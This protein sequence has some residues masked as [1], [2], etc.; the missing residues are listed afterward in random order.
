MGIRKGNPVLG[1]FVNVRSMDFRFG[2]KGRDVSITQIIRHA[3]ELTE[4]D[5]VDFLKL[6]FISLGYDEDIVKRLQEQNWNVAL[7]YML[8]ERRNSSDDALVI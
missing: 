3:L 2:I 1:Q 5:F 8:E 6:G 4:K 7:A